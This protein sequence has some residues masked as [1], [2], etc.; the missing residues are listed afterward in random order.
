MKQAIIVCAGFISLIYSCW[1][2]AICHVSDTQK[3]AV[4]S[5]AISMANSVGPC[6]TPDPS[7]L[8][9]LN[10]GKVTDITT[11][12]LLVK[13]LKEDAAQKI[14]QNQPF[15]SGKVALYVLALQSSCSDPT[16]LPNCN[17]D[18]V[19]LLKTKTQEEIDSIKISGSPLTTWYQVGLDVLALCVMSQPSAITTACALAKAIPTNPSGHTFSVDT[20]AVAVMGFTC[21]L[22]MKDVPAD[23][24]GTVKFTV[25]ALLDMILDAQNGGL[26]GN[27]YSTGLAGQA[28][29][30]A[31]SYY[32]SERWD[33]LQ[34]LQKLINLI[35]EGKF[36]LPIAAAQL[37][38]FLW[39]KSYVSV[40]EISCPSNDAQLIS[41]DYTIYNDLI[42]EPFK[43][44]IVVSVKEGSTLLQIMQK[45][46]ELDP[47]HFSFQTETS[48]WGVYVT[49]I[50]N[51]GGST[52]DKT[53]WQFF[54]DVTPL[55]EGV[56]TYKP[57]NK[58]HILAIIS[59]Y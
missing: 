23:T 7:V 16:E 22:E 13:Q 50:N 56:G 17:T 38:P 53:Y 48:S 32:S 1:A 47:K 59:K 18:L 20:A 9:A 52:N 19:N 26:I 15:S 34:T 11:K 44:S 57:K 39:G 30:V 28:L 31:K 21:V 36:S 29:I 12:H 37:L 14:N 24:F 55:I 3:S 46:A 42:G 43:Y 58:E 51:L 45:A 40:K 8:L 25:G 49:S 6:V 35:P 33:C 41:V 4:S 5:L 27:I 54:N 10:L 2:D